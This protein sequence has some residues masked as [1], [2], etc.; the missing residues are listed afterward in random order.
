MLS[1]CIA[2]VGNDSGPM[3]LAAM[4]GTPCVAVFSAREARGRWDPF[5]TR[6]VMLRKQTECA[7][8]MLEECVSE[9]NRCLT[10]I[11]VEDVV[12]AAVRVI[13]DGLAE[14]GARRELVA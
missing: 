10:A 5:G 4:V 6:H 14:S 12:A 1:R 7:G 2:Y 11:G 3:H 9:A 13:R 8:C